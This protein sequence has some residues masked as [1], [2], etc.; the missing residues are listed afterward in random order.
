MMP[1]WLKILIGALVSFIIVFVV[2]GV[3][4]YHVLKTSL[5]DYN[6]EA[7]SVHIKNNITVYRDSMAVP[8]IVAENDEDAAFGLGYVHAQERM[9]TMD[10]ARRAGEGRLSEIFGSATIPFDKMFLTVGIKRTVE[11]N[12]KKMSA[13]ELKFLQAY[14]NGVNFYIKQAKGKYP[15]EFDALGYDPYPWKPEHSLIIARMMAWELNI[16]WWIDVSFTDLV[17]KFGEEKVKEI[18]PAYPENG[19]FIIPPELKK[20][21]PISKSFVETD[22]AFRKFMGLRGTHIGSNNWV[23]NGN[24]SASGKPLIANDTHLAFSAPGKWFAAVIKSEARDGWDAAG[25]T[26]PGI[27]MIVIGKNQNITWTVTNLMTDDADFYIEK[28]DSAKK[29]Y[30]YN[31]N[32]Y[33]LQ[34]IKDTIKVKDSTSVAFEIK[35]TRHGPLISDIHPYSI[36]YKDRKE[37]TVPLS[38]RWLGDDYSDEFLAFYKINKAKNWDEFKSSFKTYSVPGQNF[39]YADKEGN[40]GYIMGTRIPIRNS[41]SAAFVCD[42]TTSKYDWKGILNAEDLPNLFNPPSNF[43]ASANNKTIKNFK[44]YISNLWEPPSRYERIV[45]LLSQKQKH[46]VRDYE[47][48]QND[49]ISPYAEKITQYILNA[50]KNVKV[51]DK[52]LNLTLKL[53]DEWNYEFDEYS[54]VPAIYA[55]FFNHLLKNIFYD[56]M[57]EEQF[58]EF[59]FVANVPYRSVIQVLSDSTCTW[60]DNTNTKNRIETKNEIIRK[61]L[62]D[63]LT[64]LEY[65]FGKDLK[66]WQWGKLHQ[67]TFKHAFSGVSSILDNFINIGP[68]SIGGDGTTIFNTEYPFYESIKKYPRFTHDQFENNLGPSMRYIFDYSKPDLFYMILPTGQSGN[69]MSDHYKDMT[70]MWLHRKYITVRTDLNSIEQNK[71][72][73]IIKPTR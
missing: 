33:N 37:K 46:S 7:A 12:M 3:I 9:F 19:P 66:E 68:Y 49:F 43:I 70:D 72:K 73:Y 45:E 4:F 28:L 62:S 60:F 15:V 27:P 17:Q 69:V 39:V 59:L 2:G 25:F 47:K 11:A 23:V 57:G 29:K 1:K 56:E 10:I 30:L 50:F 55:V 32:W 21:P 31:D 63:A 65:E 6:G 42:G 36:L 51:T 58:N 22:K 41:E 67:V 40:I 53:F 48:Y 8:Y 61:S 64:E 26:L 34:V 24:M 44:Y 14:S 35:S 5:P 52:N 20:Y 71:N 16:S 13:E 54:Q 38:M 18:L